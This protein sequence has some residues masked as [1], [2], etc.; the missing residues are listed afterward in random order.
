MGFET[1]LLDYSNFGLARHNPSLLE[2]FL[3]VG[4]E[5]HLDQAEGAYDLF[6]ASH[7]IE[8]VRN[9]EK[10]LSKAAKALSSR[11]V[12]AVTIPNDDSDYQRML[13]QDGFVDS[14]WWIAPPEHL[15][16]F[17]IDTFTQLAAGV[18]L[19]AHVVYASLPIDW[20]VLNPLSNY[21]TTPSAGPSS[22]RARLTLDAFLW[23]VGSE[24]DQGLRVALAQAGLGRDLTFLLRK[25]TVSD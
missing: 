4:A 23:E 8:H 2:G 10:L 11:G 7:L 19:Y 1:R 5:E 24:K 21:V 17:N 9:P 6:W 18:G 20:Y 14:D 13:K 3:Q 12:L 16:Y 25:K 15:S 22:H